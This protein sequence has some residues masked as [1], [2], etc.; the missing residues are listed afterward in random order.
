MDGSA[1]L[2]G[3]LNVFAVAPYAG[4]TQY[5]LLTAGGGISGRFDSDNVASLGN[6]ASLA[7]IDTQL[8]YG[9]NDLSLS[10]ARNSTAFAAVALNDN[11]RSAAAALDSAAAPLSLHNEIVSMDRASG[12][13]RLQAFRRRVAWGAG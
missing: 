7:F 5:T 11:Q 8:L 10:V 9:S 3:T 4:D 6:L 13:D 12:A 1:T 2:A